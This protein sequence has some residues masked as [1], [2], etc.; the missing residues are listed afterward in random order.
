M[1]HSANSAGFYRHRYSRTDSF[2]LVASQYA[3]LA[4][5][6]CLLFQHPHRRNITLRFYLSWLAF[7]DWLEFFN[8]RWDLSQG[9]IALRDLTLFGSVSKQKKWKKLTDK[10]EKSAFLP[11]GSSIWF[12]HR[13]FQIHHSARL[14]FVCTHLHWLH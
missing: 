8:L 4:A 11:V 10:L 12:L 7:F 14:H 1:H 3:R 13:D 6:F 5:L 2:H 9:D